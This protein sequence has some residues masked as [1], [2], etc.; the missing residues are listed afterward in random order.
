MCAKP[1]V[2]PAGERPQELVRRGLGSGSEPCG[3]VGRPKDRYRNY[4]GRR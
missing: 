4:Q 2:G 3:I 1:Y